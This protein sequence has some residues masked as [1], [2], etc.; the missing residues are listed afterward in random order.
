MNSP[1]S[2]YEE[3]PQ[4]PQ[5]HS[6]ERSTF[7]EESQRLLPPTESPPPAAR[8][9]TAFRFPSSHS[10]N[11][12]PS[13]DSDDALP[14]WNT[15]PLK[16]RRGWPRTL[17]L[18]IFLAAVTMA[19]WVYVWQKEAR[20]N[21]VWIPDEETIQFGKSP[22]PYPLERTSIL[23]YTLP[24]RTKGRDIVD[25]MGKRF[26]LLSVNWYGASDEL[27]VPGGLEIRHR[28]DI[29][30]TIRRMGFNSVRLPYADEL[31]TSNPVIEPHLV[32]ANPDLAGLRALDVFEAVV[33]ALTDAGLAV[34]VNNHITKATCT[35]A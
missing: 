17:K 31:V 18:V 11:D 6:D 8:R 12:N 14:S 27:F 24:L 32:M 16:K 15:G 1:H 28:S 19:G 5:F 23:N 35:T 4:S 25:A 2:Q 21:T 3:R 30:K 33:M 20:L 22:L 34:I 9:A 10:D 26:K 29:A 7:A 13:W